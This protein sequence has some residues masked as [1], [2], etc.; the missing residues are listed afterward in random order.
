VLDEF[1]KNNLKVC[2]YDVWSDYSKI[3]KC[4]W[5]AAGNRGA[6]IPDSVSDTTV[7]KTTCLNINPKILQVSP[8]QLKGTAIAST[9]LH[10]LKNVHYL[11]F[12]DTS[13]EKRKLSDL[14]YLDRGFSNNPKYI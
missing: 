2:T 13:Y 3:N 14:V 10:T 12:V 4:V 6:K 8:T 9:E 5:T 1:S 7:E 11:T